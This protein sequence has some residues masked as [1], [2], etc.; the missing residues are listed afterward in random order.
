MKQRILFMLLGLVSVFSLFA[1]SHEHKFGDWRIITAATCEETGS[2]VRTCKCGEVETQAIETLGHNVSFSKFV[3]VSCEE[4]YI[5]NTCGRCYSVII[6]H[7][8]SRAHSY[9][10]W[11]IQELATCET[12]GR[13]ARMCS[14][15]MKYEYRDITAKGHSII[16]IS[17]VAPTCT[18]QG[19]TESKIC[20]VCDKTLVSKEVIAEIGHDYQIDVVEP[21]YHNKG[22]TN[23]ICNNCWDSY[24]TDEVDKLKCIITWKNW[25][26]TILKTDNVEYGS[27]PSYTG[28]TP[29]KLSTVEYNYEFVGW[30]KTIANATGDATYTAQFKSVVKKYTVT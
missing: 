5:E 16:T 13:E 18:D 4:S 29:K 27:K 23:H 19:Y 12:N 24:I 20:G 10:S 2:K 14:T 26:G 17:A 28:V 9:G 11:S 30:N 21:T 1:C 3:F 25:D 7:Q 22:Y 8:P 15:C 6:E